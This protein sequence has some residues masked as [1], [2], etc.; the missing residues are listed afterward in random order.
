MR[1]LNAAQMREADRRT[2]EEIGIPSMVLME[3]AGRQVVAAMEA[4]LDSLR[5]ARVAILCGRGNNGGDGFVVARVL[6][7]RGIEV[8][9]FLVGLAGEI[10]G[11]ARANLEILERL[12]LAAIQIASEQ[13][14]AEHGASVA[15][16]DVI[17]DAL[18]GTGLS[19]PLTGLAEMV[20]AD[21]NAMGLPVV[22]VDLPSGLSADRHDLIGACV[23]ASLTVTL[24]AP[25]LPLVLRPGAAHTG[26][27]VIADIGIPDEVIDRVDGP[28]VEVLT[29]DEVQSIIQP[30]AAEA[31]KGEFGHVVVVA[32]SRGKT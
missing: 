28:R 7:Q 20:V 27:L 23:D 9:V 21:V 18:F 6:H 12:G 30:R 4:R 15:G 22:S 8:Q 1:I 24:A 10:H 29:R 17:V 16:H 2:I 32:G 26:D 3:N 25:K 11:D 19:A 13:D 31:H 5:E 14:W